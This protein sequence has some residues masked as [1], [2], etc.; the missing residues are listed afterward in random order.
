LETTSIKETETVPLKG[1]D[2]DHATV[3]Q[4][5]GSKSGDEGNITTTRVQGKASL[6]ASSS[7]NDESHIDE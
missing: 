5:F 2:K 4:D 7:S 6:H 1:E 3:Q